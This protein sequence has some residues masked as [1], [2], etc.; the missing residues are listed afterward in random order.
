M[1][2]YFHSTK[3]RISYLFVSLLTL[4]LFS[5][6]TNA[7]F[8]CILFSLFHELGH[9]FAAMLCKVKITSLS[10]EPF[11]I[12]IKCDDVSSLSAFKRIFIF[13]SGV[14]VNLVFSLI[15]QF[16]PINFS[17][18]FFN[19][20]PIGWLDGGR[21]LFEIL[22]AFLKEETADTVHSVLSFLFLTPLSAIAVMV[23]NKNPTLLLVCVY[24]LITILLK[25]HRM[26]K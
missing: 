26:L 24:L 16:S 6:K 1:T 3:I 5:K 10:F 8:F 17:L 9:V 11:G 21:I 4:L 23:S 18:L 25:K 14:L 22:S 19:L 2:F 15:P 20:L 12:C 13:S 7:V